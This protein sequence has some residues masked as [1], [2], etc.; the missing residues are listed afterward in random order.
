[1]ASVANQRRANSE[2]ARVRDLAAASGYVDPY[3]E[4]GTALVATIDDRC[5]HCSWTLFVSMQNEVWCPNPKCTEHRT[6]LMPED[7]VEAVAF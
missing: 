4:P 6:I 2:W 3:P 5:E 1:M 7:D